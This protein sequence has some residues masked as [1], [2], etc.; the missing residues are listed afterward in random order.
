[1]QYNMEKLH[2]QRNVCHFKF[3]TR[4]VMEYHNEFYCCLYR[5]LS[6]ISIKRSKT[7]KK[8]HWKSK[9]NLSWT[10]NFITDWANA[11]SMAQSVKNLSQIFSALFFIYK[12]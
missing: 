1:M 8:E 10:M 3:L 12:N 7:N 11:K 6:M 4:T 2:P 9:T 5:Q